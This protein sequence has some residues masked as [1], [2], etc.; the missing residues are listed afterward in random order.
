MRGAAILMVIGI[1][2]LPQPLSAPW[3]ILLDSALRP[4]VPIFLFASG[5]LS[6]G[7]DGIPI[8]R[9]LKAAM[10]PYAIAFVAAYLYMALHNPQM[11]HRPVV[12]F[13]RF[14]LAY[15]FVYYYVFVYVGCTICIWLV[16]KLARPDENGLAFLAALLMTAI[17]LGL[18]AGA[19]IDPL[20]TK[21]NLSPSLIEEARM[22]DIPFWFSF[23]ALGFLVGMLPDRAVLSDMKPTLLIITLATFAAY[24]AVRLARIGDYA[25][26]DSIAFFLYASFATLLLFSSG[27]SSTLIA[28]LGSGSYFIYLWHIFVIM[29]LRDH[30]GLGQFNPLIEFTVTFAITTA[31]IVTILIAVRRFSSS[32]VAHWLGA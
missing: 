30:A 24:G 23:L 12:A 27:L 5:F 3:Q 16:L 13:A 1:H 8:P 14:S 6:A 10:I 19:Y 20:M 11:D 29:L 26:Y 28:K 31:V 2:S 15:V 9:R 4:C 7:K 22:R 18:L 32:R 25:D 21:Y 17:G